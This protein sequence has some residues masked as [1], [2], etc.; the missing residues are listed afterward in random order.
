MNQR[1][2]DRDPVWTA[3][4]A[5]VQAAAE[6]EPILASFLHMTV[7]RHKRLEDVLAFHLSSK[8]AT[9]T[10]D[11]R[12]LMELIAEALDSDPMVGAAVR[13]DIKAAYE[14]DPACTSYSTPLLYYKGFHALASYRITHWLWG[15]GRQTLA[16]YLQN[17]IS[18]AFSVDI[19]PAASIGHGILLDHGH[20][21]VVGETAVI[22][23]NV[24]I[25]HNVTLG[26]TGKESGD[27]HPKIRTGVLI[28]AGAKILGNIE[29]GRGAKI[30]AGSVVLES[31]PPHVT[32]AGVP[33]KI[34]GMAD[35]AEPALNMNHRFDCSK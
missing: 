9:S 7:L 19:H 21:F 34:V 22:E 12:T 2:I 20:G 25:L 28:G 16:L 14:R 10:M 13:A 26:G 31:V 27:R 8:L 30:G 33:A 24:S 17:R 35:S 4:H 32:V 23:D 15:H 29:V 18:E 1:M 11:A 5:E 3:I 6:D